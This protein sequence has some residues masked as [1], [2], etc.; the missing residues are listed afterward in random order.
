MIQTYLTSV[1]PAY[2]RAYYR[3]Q[4]RIYQGQNS[5]L[6]FFCTPLLLFVLAIL[7][8]LTNNKTQLKTSVFD[9]SNKMRNNRP[10]LTKSLLSLILFGQVLIILIFV[11][12]PPVLRLFVAAKLLGNQKLEHRFY[13]LTKLRIRVFQS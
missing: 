8:R 12:S 5:N 10:K 9:A 11:R 6:G 13:I 2:Y 4:N 1:N 3:A 7:S